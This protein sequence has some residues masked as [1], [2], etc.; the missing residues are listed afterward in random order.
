MPCEACFAYG[1]PCPRRG[2]QTTPA[3]AQRY[4]TQV[5]GIAGTGAAPH[6]CPRLQRLRWLCRIPVGAVWFRP[7]PQLGGVVTA[8]T[9][10]G[11]SHGACDLTLEPL[12]ALL[13][14]SPHWLPAPVPWDRVVRLPRP[15]ELVCSSR[16]KHQLLQESSPVSCAGTSPPSPSW[17]A[18][19]VQGHSPQVTPPAEAETQVVDCLGWVLHRVCRRLPRSQGVGGSGQPPAQ[20][21]RVPRERGSGLRKPGLCPGHGTCGRCPRGAVPV[22][23]PRVCVHPLCVWEEVSSQARLPQHAAGPSSLPFGRG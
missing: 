4:G 3:G 22:A 21:Q 15:S 12:V 5:P 10:P 16:W 19:A 7:R 14:L 8:G 9:G 1:E 17:G 23:R 6:Q 11:G 18:P 2:R 13:P 20:P